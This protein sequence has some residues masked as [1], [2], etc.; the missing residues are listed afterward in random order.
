MSMT[1]PPGWY[2]DPGAPG[3]ERWWDGAAWSAHTRAAGQAFGLGQPVTAVTAPAARR[4]R[5][6]VAAGV[7]AAVLVAAVA[8]GLALLGDTDDEPGTTG[9]TRSATA[10]VVVNSP[11]TSASSAPSGDPHTLVDQLNG[12]TLPIPDGWERSDDMVGGLVTMATKDTYDCPGGSGFC[13]HGKAT[14][15]TAT[16]TDLKTAEAV[17][18][19]DIADAADDAYDHDAVGTRLYNG[20]T[21]HHEVKSGPVAVD[22]RT[23]YLVRWQVKTGSGPGGY[24]ESLAFP[25]TV[26]SEAMVIARFAFDAGPGGPPLALM[27]TITRGIAPIGGGGTNGGV[28]TSLPPPS[29]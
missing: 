13:H 12:I 9:T 14:T 18:K 28:G 19:N 23:G 20:I 11:S 21:A 5:P 3:T 1:T 25:S 2:P 17:A 8:T 15:S 6:L 26:G 4:R 10:P 29:L 24:V 7:A 22:G 16:A 27:D